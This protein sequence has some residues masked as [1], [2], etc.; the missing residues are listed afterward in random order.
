MENDKE[1][2]LKN[3]S[4][5]LEAD[6]C[7]PLK[8]ASNQ[9]KIECQCFSHGNYPGTQL[10]KSIIPELIS[11][12]YW[13]CTSDQDWGLEW[14]CNEGIE[15]TLL[16]SGQL[17][18]DYG[19][20]HHLLQNGDMTAMAPWQKHKVGDPNITA[21]HLYWII[22]DVKVSQPNEKWTW[23]DWV[24]LSKKELTL[25]ENY[26][27]H[28]VISSSKKDL[29]NIFHK[30][31]ELLK[32]PTPTIKDTH[33][34]VYINELLLALLDNYEIQETEDS[35]TITIRQ[36]VQTFIEQL[37]FNLKKEWTLDNMANECDLQR[38]RFS[39]YFK[40][41][42]NTSPIKHINKLRLVEAEKLLSNGQLP[43]IE[44]AN[45]CGFYSSEH[46]SQLF[47]KSHG[48]TPNNWRE[49]NNSN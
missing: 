26:I 49:N 24:L 36:K 37:P 33:L 34:K 3:E 42:T 38:T 45:A 14:H 40:S 13:N 1:I 7:E 25:L 19:K 21:S 20:K 9:N 6:T 47:K 17:H 22:L 27:R 29:D 32:S 5:P 15:I 41:L 10:P 11:L 48:V 35:V 43:I 16:A 44:I 46:F 12:G 8:N 31:D 23:P 28:T 30:M 18:F 2:P 4:D 39:H